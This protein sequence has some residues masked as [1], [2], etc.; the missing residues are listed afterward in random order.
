MSRLLYFD[1]FSGIAGD[2]ALGALIDLGLDVDRLTAALRTLTLSPWRLDVRRVT[3]SSLTGVKVDVWVGDVIAD[4]QPPD[5]HHSH[6]HGHG[7]HYSELRDMIAGSDLPPPV[8]ARALSAFGAL[9]EAEARVHG[10][11]VEDVH[12]HEVGAVDSVVD[13]VGCAWGLWALGVDVV[14]SAPLPIS[15]GFVQ[16]AHGRLPLPAP[17]T[18][19]LLEGL[20]IVPCPVPKELVTPTGAAMIKAWARRVGDIPA[21]T[22]SGVGWGAGTLDLPDR[23]NLLRLMIGETTDATEDCALITTNLDD[24][25]PELAGHLLDAL[26]TAGA[27]DAW[28]T[29]IQMK[30]N[31]PGVMVGALA[32]LGIQAQVEGILLRESTAIGL[33]RQRVAR[34][35]L[36][37]RIE[38]VQTPFGPIDVKIA[39]SQ[40]DPDAQ[41]IAPEYES[42]RAA[43]A[44]AGVPLKRVYQH[45]I[46]GWLARGA[47]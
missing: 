29:P 28:F 35:V 30:K 9:A 22:V 23:P 32:P 24:M 1:C 19:H 26:L 44:A 3:K 4:Q 13:L 37:R 8:I 39:G 45:A 6:E 11:T 47:R 46:A 25:N 38:S 43:A 17:A 20:P 31:R 18:A 2:M 5:H 41:N 10:T 12:F 33:R 15:R 14:E 21:M 16:T 40:S 42:C 34:T 7:R 27:L 36:P